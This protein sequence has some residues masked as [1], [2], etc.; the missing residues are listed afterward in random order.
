LHRTPPRKLAR[1]VT[2]SQQELRE[3]QPKPMA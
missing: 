1:I 3:I 2:P